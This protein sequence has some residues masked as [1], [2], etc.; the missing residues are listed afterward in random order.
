M[1]ICVIGRART[2][3][4]VFCESVAVYHGL[5]NYNETYATA[6]TP[7][8]NP[9]F[10]RN[11]SKSEKDKFTWNRYQDLILK[12]TEEMFETKNFITKLW[13]KWFIQ[14]SEG[15]RV[16]S[17][18]LQDFNI[19]TNLQ[20]YFKILDYDK[21]YWIDRSITDSIC[22]L[23]FVYTVKKFHSPISTLKQPIIIDV[24]SRWVQ[25]YLF[26]ILISSKFR[27]FLD[28]NKIVYTSLTYDEVPQ[29]CIKNYAGVEGFEFVDGK[30]NYKTLI[31]N[32]EEVE[33]YV[34]N[35]LSSNTYL[36]ENIKFDL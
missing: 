3:S 13:P 33:N 12:I 19:I 34:F 32:Y 18:N 24:N 17:E 5:K 7:L 35:F 30:R 6:S 28:E 21:I 14:N 23:S 2:R 15:K 36:V 11:L 8:F 16:I 22:S 27:N 29:Y 9:F 26:D 25:H 31:K 20:K 10:F 1:N 4:S